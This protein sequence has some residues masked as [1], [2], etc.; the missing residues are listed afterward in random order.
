MSKNWERAWMG[1]ALTTTFIVV[2]FGISLLSG[3]PLM[4]AVGILHAEWSVI[5][6]WSYWESVVL[7]WSFGVLWHRVTYKTE[8]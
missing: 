4:L 8:V 7:L 2:S 3:W 5:P 6:A 1:A